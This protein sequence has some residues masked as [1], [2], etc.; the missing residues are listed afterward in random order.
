MMCEGVVIECSTMEKGKH[1]DS[2]YTD[3]NIT[4]I[5]EYNIFNLRRNGNNSLKLEIHCY[6]VKYYL[7]VNFWV[8]Y[9]QTL[10]LKQLS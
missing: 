3:L 7:S 1:H 8:N 2:L 4:E 10:L 6:F 9:N 5:V